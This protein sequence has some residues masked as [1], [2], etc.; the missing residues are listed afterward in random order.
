M[1]GDD[2]QVIDLNRAC[3]LVQRLATIKYFSMGIRKNSHRAGT[4]SSFSQACTCFL[5]DDVDMI[6]D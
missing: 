2:L 3:L 4:H 1:E 6:R 5:S